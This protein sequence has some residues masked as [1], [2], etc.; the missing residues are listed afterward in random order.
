MI[1]TGILADGDPIELLNGWLVTKMTKTPRHRLV[2]GLVRSALERIIP[3]GWYVDSQQPITLAASEPEP[4]GAVVR[5]Q[6][7]D[8]ADRHPGPADVGLVVEVADSNLDRDREFRR[9]IYAQ[10]GVPCYSVVNLID[11]RVEVYS[12]CRPASGDASQYERRDFTA[13]DEVPVVL[14]GQEIGHVAV[15]EILP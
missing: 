6:R 10:A 3:P 9:T 7:R 11:D 2:T 15:R 4:D 14:G 1:R 8:Y 5:G 12:L 13:V